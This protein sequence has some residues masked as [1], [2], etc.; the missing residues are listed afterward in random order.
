M[1]TT[2]R[3]ARQRRTSRLLT[4]LLAAVLG[5][6]GTATPAVAGPNT[7]TMTRTTNQTLQFGG[8]NNAYS[9]GCYRVDLTGQGN[10][11]LI[12]TN[13]F[14]IPANYF[15]AGNRGLGLRFTYQSAYGWVSLNT[16]GGAV[17]LPNGSTPSGSLARLAV[18][19]IVTI[20]P[21]TS[22]PY[23]GQGFTCTLPPPAGEYCRQFTITGRYGQVTMGQ[24][25]GTSDNRVVVG[26]LAYAQLKGKY[27]WNGNRVTT[28]Q[29][30]AI[31]YSFTSSPVPA[32][33]AFGF[34]NPRNG[35]SQT[36]QSHFSV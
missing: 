36:Y 10:Q 35:V 6:V 27:C 17:L 34:S 19:S 9:T 16:D 32:G 26:A 7:L 25:L 14:W 31:Q 33:L 4:L 5:A 11:S 21:V 29:T 20:T 28:K 22:L 24:I 3:S 23:T 12:G 18:G 15:I 13:T 2:P 30:S 8:A 1:R